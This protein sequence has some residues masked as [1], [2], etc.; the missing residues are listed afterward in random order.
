MKEAVGRIKSRLIL[1]DGVLKHI[2]LKEVWCY[3]FHCACSYHVSCQ[4]THKWWILP[5][6]K[7]QLWHV[8]FHQVLVYT[9]KW[10]CL[11]Y[12]VYICV[13]TSKLHIWWRDLHCIRRKNITPVIKI[14]IIKIKRRN[15]HTWANLIII[16]NNKFPKHFCTWKYTI[17][18]LET[19]WHEKAEG[20]STTRQ[21][22]NHIWRLFFWGT[23][24]LIL[25]MYN[26][27]S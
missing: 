27:C 2:T 17:L 11:I 16:A 20:G 7:M 18:V 24:H 21:I 12:M 13:V 15:V 19:A 10:T 26:S 9:I 6:S 23:N 1:G 5:Y 3:S 25:L 14:W 8:T 4:N 22:L